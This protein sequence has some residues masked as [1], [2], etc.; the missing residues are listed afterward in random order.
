MAKI[1]KL[2]K[3][4]MEGT[5]KRM[6]LSASEVV[7]LASEVATTRTVEI[8]EETKDKNTVVKAIEGV[9]QK[10]RCGESK[11]KRVVREI[12]EAGAGAYNSRPILIT[13][14]D[15]DKYIDENFAA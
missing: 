7:K 11:A 3:S 1:H 13:Q 2:K 6:N 12:I 5:E 9:R 15:L 10:L 4:K 14:Y 8:L